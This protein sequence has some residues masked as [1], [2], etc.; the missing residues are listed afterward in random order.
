MRD[1]Y[2]KGVGMGDQDPPYRPCEMYH[3]QIFGMTTI[4]LLTSRTG[5]LQE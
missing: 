1:S 2:K 5:H 4:M 3:M